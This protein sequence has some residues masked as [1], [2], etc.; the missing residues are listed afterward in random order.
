MIKAL[1]PIDKDLGSSIAIRYAGDLSSRVHMSLHD[2]H[3]VDITKVGIAPGSGWVR[4]TWENA[5]IES[6]RE[7]IQRFLEIEKVSHPLLKTPKMLFGDRTEKLLE[8]LTDGQYDLFMEGAVPSFNPLDFYTLIHSR[9][10]RQMTCPVL[11][12]KNLVPP[13]KA[14]FLVTESTDCG[15][16]STCLA[17]IF[18][19][20]K[21]SMDLVV[22]KFLKSGG[23]TLHENKSFNGCLENAEKIFLENGLRPDSHSVIEGM[24]QKISEFLRKY[25]MVASAL[26]KKPQKS[27]PLMELLGRTASPTMIC[28]D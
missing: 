3:V 12:I 17:K 28:W 13:E 20:T 19:N 24:P 21:M 22:V 15:R 10:Y 27:D 9:L 11:V 4:K 7:E 2:V 1:I 23:M 6:E 16:F 25:G 18:E 26:T 8:E 5:L 14:A